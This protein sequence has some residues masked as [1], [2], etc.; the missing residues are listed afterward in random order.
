MGVA[1]R[2]EPGDEVPVCDGVCEGVPVWLSVAVLLGVCDDVLV[3][4]GVCV[5]VPDLEGV[6]VG[7]CVVVLV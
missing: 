1:E 4:D 7:L 5:G 6:R 3:F 2:E